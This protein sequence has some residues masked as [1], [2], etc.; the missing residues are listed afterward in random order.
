[1]TLNDTNVASI[2]KGIHKGLDASIVCTDCNKGAFSFINQDAPG[3]FDDSDKQAASA[4]CGASFV[5]GGIPP[6]LVL[7]DY[8]PA[9]STTA[10]PTSTPPAPTSTAPVQTSAAAPEPS[11]PVPGN[12]APRGSSMSFAG[13]GVSAL[14]ALITGLAMV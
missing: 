9:A 6:N 7:G 2:V 14:V 12:A 11:V 4:K 10:A 13:V 1:M 8:E 3:T 5:D